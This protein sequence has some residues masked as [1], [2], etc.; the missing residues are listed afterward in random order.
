MRPF[1]SHAASAE[2][3]ML[4]C[5]GTAQPM[6]SNSTADRP[7]ASALARPASMWRPGCRPRRARILRTEMSERCR[8]AEFRHRHRGSAF[9]IW[10]PGPGLTP[11][12][13]GAPD[14]NVCGETSKSTA[15]DHR[16][17][18][19]SRCIHVLMGQTDLYLSDTLG[20]MI[21][22]HDNHDFRASPSPASPAPKIA[23]KIRTYVFWVAV[24]V[25][26]STLRS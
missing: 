15:A 6:N 5:H 21:P 26:I 11:R 16:L 19:A 12:R 22:S 9:R 4:E 17:R 7:A 18:S 1:S 3:G 2:L 25:A 20:R 24:S 23:R 13:A 10:G 14:L 8:H